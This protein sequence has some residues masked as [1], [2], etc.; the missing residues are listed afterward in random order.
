MFR[1]FENTLAWVLTSSEGDAQVCMATQPVCHV[2]V[3]GHSCGTEYAGCLRL[4]FSSLSLGFLAAAHSVPAA[5]PL[6]S[7]FWHHYL[8]MLFKPPSQLNSKY[9]TGTQ[10]P[11]PRLDVL[12]LG[13]FL[14]RSVSCGV[15]QP[16]DVC[17]LQT[18]C[19]S[20]QYMLHS[21]FLSSE[22][23]VGPQS[24]STLS[25]KVR[26]LDTSDILGIR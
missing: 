22:N 24:L 9:P 13:L 4:S 15:S 6:I 11:L 20:R 21:T 1:H 2:R 10:L 17:P 8:S 23:I 12:H 7:P 5:P 16:I 3:R 19:F 25:A 26:Q 14:R 18:S